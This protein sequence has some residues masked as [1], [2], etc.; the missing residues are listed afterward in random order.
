MAILKKINSYFTKGELALWLVSEMVII[1][2]NLIMENG[3]YLSLIASMI[4]VTALIFN[5]KGNP[6]GPGLM[7]VFCLIYGYISL[8]FKYYGEMLTY[9][10]MSMPMSIISLIT[11]LK[12]PYSS[13]KAEVAV[14]RNMSK[15]EWVFIAILTTMVTIAFYVIL[16]FFNTANL[17]PSTIS[18]ITSF[19]AVY[20][21]F[22]RSPYFAL[23]YALNDIV[24]I[25]LWTLAAF[26]DISYLSVVVCFVAFLAN[27]TYSF[28]N[29]QRMSKR[30][31]LGK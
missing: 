12:N 30:Q 19:A 13:H 14:N 28:I 18:V 17:I 9:V 2:S 27:D 10:G 31:S 24:L 16:K 6:A 11:W 23:G 20:L 29:W 15:K 25:V 7:V 5:A 21:S 22:R 4:G 8:G 1:A 3:G 26:K